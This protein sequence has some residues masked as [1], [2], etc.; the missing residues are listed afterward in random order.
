MDKVYT[1]S[2]SECYTSSSEA[3]RFY[4]KSSGEVKS[5]RSAREA[6]NLTAICEPII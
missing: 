6:D 2:G 3:F 4:Q 5:G 1:T